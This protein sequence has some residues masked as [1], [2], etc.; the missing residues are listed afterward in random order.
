L[1]TE[2]ASR[3]VEIVTI[4]AVVMPESRTLQTAH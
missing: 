3:Q 4:E 2:T 1:P